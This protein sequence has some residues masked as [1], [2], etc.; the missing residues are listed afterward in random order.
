MKRLPDWIGIG[1]VKCGTSWAWEQL[2]KHPEIYSPHKEVSYFNYTTLFKQRQ[3]EAVFEG[4]EDDQMLGE[5]TPDYFHHYEAMHN[6]KETCPWVKL[7]VIFR[8][9]VERAFSNYKHA[10][11]EGRLKSH[12]T[13]DQSKSFWR[14]RN[15]SIY[16]THLKQWYE[17]F[18]RNKIKVMWYEDIK[19]K[20]IEFLQEIFRFLGINDSFVPEGYEEQF[21]FR[22]HGDDYISSLK[23]SQKDREE[24]LKFYLPYTEELEKITGKDLS[25]WKE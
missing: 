12:I 8:H 13:F 1:C 6:I 18:G 20:P 9:P 22:Y 15:R 19:T 16:S 10:L 5:W 23:L 25:H 2:S 3:Y 21:K 17:L 24:W 11:F 4:G 7:I 14:V